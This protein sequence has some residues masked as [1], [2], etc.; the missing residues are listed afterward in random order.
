M[1]VEQL[2]A[3]VVEDALY[4]HSERAT[5]TTEQAVPETEEV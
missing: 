1:A 3:S 5:G 2:I 4:P